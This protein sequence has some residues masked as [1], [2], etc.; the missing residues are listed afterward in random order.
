MRAHSWYKEFK[1]DNTID[2]IIDEAGGW[3]LLS[4]LYEKHIPIYFFAHHIGDKEFDVYPW[5]I[6]TLARSVY[7][8]MIGL[9]RH[10]P[11]IAV[12]GSTREELIDEF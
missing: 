2:I 1:R 12:S 3:P 6:G 5:P 8:Y 10:T 4:P 9:Y 11:T 7:R